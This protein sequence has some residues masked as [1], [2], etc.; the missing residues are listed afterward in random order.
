MLEVEFLKQREESRVTQA[1][2][3][4]IALDRHPGEVETGGHPAEAVIGFQE[5]GPAALQ[6]ELIGN[7]QSHGATANHGDPACLL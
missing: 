4:V 2:K 5:H 1:V 3:V 6:G 7:R